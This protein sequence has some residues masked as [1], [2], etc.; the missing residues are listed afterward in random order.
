MICQVNLTGY[1]MTY[2]SGPTIFSIAHGHHS[3]TVVCVAAQRNVKKWKTTHAHKEVTEGRNLERKE[4]ESRV[5]TFFRM[6][7]PQVDNFR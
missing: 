2:K 7:G 4:K 1:S 5:I 6:S 3:I